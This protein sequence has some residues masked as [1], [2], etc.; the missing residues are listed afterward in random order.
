MVL[1]PLSVVRGSSACA[2]LD[3]RRITTIDLVADPLLVEIH[4]AILAPCVSAACFTFPVVPILM[5]TLYSFHHSRN[6]ARRGFEGKEKLHIARFHGPL[7]TC[8]YY[9]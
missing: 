1:A 6:R 8:L 2:T 3:S 7:F 5:L 4:L 9:I